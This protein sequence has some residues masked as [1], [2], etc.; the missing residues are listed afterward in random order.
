LHA[1]QWAQ[2]TIK[3]Y[4]RESTTAFSQSQVVSIAYQTAVGLEHIASL[5]F[6][7]GDVAT[8][9]LLLYNDLLV[10]LT[11]MSLR[12]DVQDDVSTSGASPSWGD[13]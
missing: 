1:D 8:R 12:C 9:N 13:H 6:V 11:C 3:Q 10:K 2:G 4:M 5:G 7:H